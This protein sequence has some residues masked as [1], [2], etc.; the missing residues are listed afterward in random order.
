LSSGLLR[1]VVWHTFTDVSEVI[2]GFIITAMTYRP[3]YEGRKYL[4]NVGRLLTKLQDETFQKTVIF[5][6]ATLRTWMLP[7][8]LSWK[9]EAFLSFTASRFWTRLQLYLFYCS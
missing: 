4:W 6:L 8:F 2:A 9:R 7:L 1:R 5:V 3:E